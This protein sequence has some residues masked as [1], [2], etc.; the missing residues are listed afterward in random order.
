MIKLKDCKSSLSE[1]TVSGAVF[2]LFDGETMMAWPDV[3][4]PEYGYVDPR[5]EN[6]GG[7]DYDMAE[8]QVELEKEIITIQD[9]IGDDVGIFP[10]EGVTEMTTSANIATA[11]SGFAVLK[12]PVWPYAGDPQVIPLKMLKKRRKQRAVV[13]PGVFMYALGG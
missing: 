9:G 5:P 11:P 4:E 13:R 10:Q 3:K 1:S 7:E 12:R 2:A 6:L 8:K